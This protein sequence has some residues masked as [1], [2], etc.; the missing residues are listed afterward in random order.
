ML[1]LGMLLY[2]NAFS[3]F[4][5]KVRLVLDVKGLSAEY[6]DGLDRNNREALRRVNDRIE[7]PVLV[8]ED[9]VVVN[10][11]DIVSYLDHQYPAVPVFPDRSKL[12]VKARK[13]ERIADTLV[14]AIMVDISY[15]KW[16]DRNDNMPDGMLDAARQDLGTVY[17][18][19]ESE[20]SE[21]NY[22]CG[23][24]S[25]AD[26]ALFPHLVS[27]RTLGVPFS[28][29]RH[30]NLV[31]WMSR[32]RK[33]KVFRA[34]IKRTRDFLSD[35]TTSKFEREKIFWR[36]E[37]IEWLLARGFDTWFFKEIK[38]GRVIWPPQDLRN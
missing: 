7:V 27:A 35:F 32:L 6:V 19:L 30:P 21:T 9:I 20:L 16:A 15:W 1:E 22:I 2:D 23:E 5:R 31:S 12:R 4:A 26:I 18:Q 29:D 3:P 38:E 11:S 36:G 24:L 34:D 28:I 37:R 14:D 33:N 17:D 10:S 8:D 13:W 25:I